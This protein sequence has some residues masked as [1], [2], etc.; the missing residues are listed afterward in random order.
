MQFQVPQY[1][2]IEDKLVGP[3]TFK[4]F[5]YLAGGGGLA[6]LIYRIIPNFG[7]ALLLLTPVILFAIAMA[8]WEINKRSFLTMLQFSLYHIIRP[9]L[10]IWK[11]LK[12]KVGKNDK[13]DVSSL[14]GNVPQLTESRL[15]DLSWSLDVQQQQQEELLTPD[16]FSPLPDLHS[17]V[18]AQH[19]AAP[20]PPSNTIPN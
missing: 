20:P 4:Q 12:K 17:L 14:T 5:I 8:F 11:N 9:K 13:Q 16:T 19:G 6:F 1:I 7:I 18:E 3:L 10:F 2:D 15:K